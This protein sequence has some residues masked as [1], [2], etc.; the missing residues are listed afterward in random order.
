MDETSDTSKN[1][2]KNNQMID[3]DIF[4]CSFRKRNPKSY[5]YNT[6][7]QAQIFINQNITIVNG[8]T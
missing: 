8:I 7:M 6:S 1:L 2:T 3:I 5:N 4:I